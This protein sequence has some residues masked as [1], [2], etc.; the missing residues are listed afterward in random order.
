VLFKFVTFAL[1]IR[2]Y[3]VALKK[4]EFV[5]VEVFVQDSAAEILLFKAHE[6]LC[7]PFRQ[8]LYE[9]VVSILGGEVTVAA[10]FDISYVTLSLSLVVVDITS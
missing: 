3:L 9:A 1:L 6:A 8:I 2:S 7:V 4:L 10:G 5:V